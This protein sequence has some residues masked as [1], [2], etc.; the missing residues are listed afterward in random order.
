MRYWYEFSYDEIAE[1][2]SL[3]NSAIKSRLHR[4]RLAL[5]QAYETE[6]AQSAQL[7]NLPY[8]APAY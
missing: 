2:L 6:N 7:Q 5:A 3:T 1:A 4:A 8:E